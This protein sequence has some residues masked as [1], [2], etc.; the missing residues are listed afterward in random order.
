MVWGPSPLPHGHMVIGS[1][2][3]IHA[4]LITPMGQ[5]YNGNGGAISSIPR[6][7]LGLWARA[8]RVERGW[9]AIEA[10]GISRR[11][12]EGYEQGRSIPV[13]QVYAL[14]ASVG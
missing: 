2:D 4:L 6:S 7:A 5:L 1:I 11:T 12:W 10:A 3:T 9:D 13:G 14:T 8:Y